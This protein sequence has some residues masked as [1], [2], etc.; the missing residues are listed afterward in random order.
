MPSVL[1][2]QL[3]MQ[4]SFDCLLMFNSIFITIQ[5]L[6]LQ[7]C[8]Q[9]DTTYPF[10]SLMRCKATVAFG[11]RCNADSNSSPFR[12]SKPSFILCAKR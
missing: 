7:V 8:W 5:D 12:G 11:S 2:G 4:T 6:K 3:F 10:V 1:L 9:G